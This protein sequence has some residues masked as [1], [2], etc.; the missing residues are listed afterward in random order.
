MLATFPYRKNF[1][2][3]CPDCP[4]EHACQIEVHSFNRFKLVWLTGPLRTH[5]DRHTSNKHN[6]STIHFVHLAETINKTRYIAVLHEKFVCNEATKKE[7]QCACMHNSWQATR[8]NY[9]QML[10][11][12]CSIVNHYLKTDIRHLDNSRREKN[13]TEFKLQLVSR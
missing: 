9:P 4:W 3:S 7:N 12:V 13:T 5:T 6:I 2:G 11:V 1:E 8:R 10:L